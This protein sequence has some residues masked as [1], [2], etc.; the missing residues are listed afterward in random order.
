MSASRAHSLSVDV[1]GCGFSGLVTA[2]YLSERGAKVRVFEKGA[3]AGGLIQTH[4]TPYGLVETAANA[5]LNSEAVEH[6]FETIELPLV[7]TLRDARARYIFRGRPRR[8]PLSVDGSVRFAA[9]LPSIMRKSE[10]AR[11]REYETIHD[12]GCRV[13]GEEA[14]RYF[15]APALQGIYAGDPARMSASLI[16]NRFFT[17]RPRGKKLKFRG[18]V[19]APEGMGQLLSRLQEY[20]AEQ[21]VEFHFSSE[22][23]AR[24]ADRPTVFCGSA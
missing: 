21:G 20:L 4:K 19:S 14:A 22:R 11:P 24:D 16:L 8:W 23:R 13:L 7:G 2:F 18:S 9:A 10:K 3:R 15:L 5:L 12:W 6:L 1:I 17:K